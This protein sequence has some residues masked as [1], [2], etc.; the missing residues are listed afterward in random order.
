MKDFC[1]SLFHLVTDPTFHRGS[2]ATG[3]VFEGFL[4]VS[5]LKL[6]LSF[7]AIHTNNVGKI[8]IT[9]AKEALGC[10][11][12]ERVPKRAE[13]L[14]ELFFEFGVGNFNKRIAKLV[15]N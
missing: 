10:A 13:S 15:L 9:N 5:V 3:E 8:P 12:V 11:V 1:K 6:L 14:S 4:H 2:T 7:K